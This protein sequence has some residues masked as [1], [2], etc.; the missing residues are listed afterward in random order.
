VFQTFENVGVA[1]TNPGYLLIGNEVIPY[2]SVSNGQ[3]NGILTAPEKDYD[4]GTPV[5]KYELG[6]ISLRRINKQ[7][8]LSMVDTSIINE[9]ITLDSYHIKLDMSSDGIDRSVE[10]SLPKLYI[11]ETKSAGGSDIS[12]SNNIQFE[13][14]EPII[15]N[16]T[17]NGTAISG[18]IKTIQGT[19]ISGNESSF[20]DVGFEPISIYENNNLNS[21]RLI[22]S[23]INE[24]ENLLNEKSFNLRIDLSSNNSLLSP[25]IDARASSITLVTNRVNNI[26]TDYSSDSRVN[27]A[28]DDPTSFKYI[29]KEV[30]LETSS[31]SIK[32]ILDAHLTPDSNVRAFYAISDNPNFSPIFIPFPGYLNLNKYKEVINFENSDGLPDDYIAPSTVLGFNDVDFREHTFTANNLP[33]FRYF[34]IKL[35]GTSTNQVHVPRIKNLRV[36]ALA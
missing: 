34:R 2:E 1:S 14:I 12:A 23:D 28:V 33:S 5:Y 22:C 9:P 26:I 10:T 29:S 32:I 16:T 35:I 20:L 27:S 19:S 17:V 24:V 13:L 6:G 7:H 4:I 15:P 31:S 18:S 8:E 30:Q 25:T 11:N 36:L 3:I 21:P